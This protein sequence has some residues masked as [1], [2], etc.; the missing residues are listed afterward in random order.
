[1]GVCG[2]KL[3]KS[4]EFCFNEFASVFGSYGRLGGLLLS[5]CIVV[6]ADHIPTPQSHGRN[7]QLKLEKSAQF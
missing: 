4:A 1:V 5:K 7:E 3:R 6:V 2:F